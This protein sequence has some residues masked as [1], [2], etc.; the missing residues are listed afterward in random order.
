MCLKCFLGH[1]INF[2]KK[3]IIEQWTSPI[4][5]FFLGIGIFRAKFIKYKI[6]CKLETLFSRFNHLGRYI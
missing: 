1:L 6:L 5:S 3:I 2:T 4:R